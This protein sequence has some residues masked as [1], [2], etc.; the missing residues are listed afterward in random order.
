MAGDDCEVTLGTFMSII[1]EI[2]V[3]K[4][5]LHV[6]MQLNEQQRSWEWHLL[7]LRA[8]KP[9][10]KLL[11]WA[12]FASIYRNQLEDKW[13]D[14]YSVRPSEKPCAHTAIRTRVLADTPLLYGQSLTSTLH[15]DA[16]TQWRQK[17]SLNGW[18]KQKT[19]CR[20]KH[21][22]FDFYL[23]TGRADMTSKAKLILNQLPSRNRF[24]LGICNGSLILNCRWHCF[25]H[26]TI[27]PDLHRSEL[28]ARGIASSD[29]SS[30]FLLWQR[31]I[32]SILP[33][34]RTSHKSP[35]FVTNRLLNHP[36]F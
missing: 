28:S 7:S 24:T 1:T 35:G 2:T 21:Q 20:S 4:E 32:C 36:K 22:G 11:G 31:W 27:F 12:P 23:R 16:C 25:S 10:I 19:L 26:F 14:S 9:K 5:L 3:S 29:A 17:A 34:C 30:I 33:P 13:W 18:I 8:G 6:P 15:T